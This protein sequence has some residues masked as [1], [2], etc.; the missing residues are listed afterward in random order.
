[1]PQAAIR[2]E[3]TDTLI[4][5]YHDEGHV[6]LFDDQMTMDEAIALVERIHHCDKTK[7]VIFQP[8]RTV[9]LYR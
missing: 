9:G 7:F 6:V 2:N 1:M 5:E 4:T 3:T 8:D